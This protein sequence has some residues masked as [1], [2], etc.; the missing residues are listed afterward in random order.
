MN[1]YRFI[2]WTLELSKRKRKPV[3]IVKVYFDIDT[4]A[5][6]F[7]E[8]PEFIEFLCK[9][10]NID[11]HPHVLSQVKSALTNYLMQFVLDLKTLTIEAMETQISEEI[12]LR[13]FIDEGLQQHIKHRQKLSTFSSVMQ[14]T[15]TL[16]NYNDGF[17]HRIGMPTKS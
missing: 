15:S 2:R 7:F 3:D 9:E 1:T 4:Q 14:S 10:H 16:K 11:K 17:F 12:G 5:Q 6:Q 8:V 13:E